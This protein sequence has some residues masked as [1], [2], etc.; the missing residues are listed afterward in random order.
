MNKLTK[1]LLIGII[2]LIP[3][4]ILVTYIGRH[5]HPYSYVSTEETSIVLKSITCGMCVS[6][7]EKALSQTEGVIRA[8]VSLKSKKAYVRFNDRITTIEKIEESISAA[9]YDA[10]NKAA[11]PEAF[12]GLSECCKKSGNS[13]IYDQNSKGGQ[14]DQ[15]SCA[16]G[17]CNN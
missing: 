14:N 3:L 1:T 6:N 2:V 10:N 16:G 8:E 9:G 15:K 13:E 12:V 5:I 17:C 11:D 4:V 7:I